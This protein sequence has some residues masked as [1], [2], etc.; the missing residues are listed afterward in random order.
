ME[1]NQK[2]KNKPNGLQLRK[3]PN[4]NHSDLN[5]PT[6]SSPSIDSEFDQPTSKDFAATLKVGREGDVKLLAINQSIDL[7]QQEYSQEEDCSS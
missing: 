5:S 7:D 3:P 2:K 6:L 4:P 1:V